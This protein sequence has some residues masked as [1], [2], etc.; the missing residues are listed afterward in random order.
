MTV[1]EHIEKKMRAYAAKMALSEVEYL[2]FKE[3]MVKLVNLA[4][5]ESKRKS[6]LKQIPT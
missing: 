5:E 4:V 2:H 3:S 1:P 6:E